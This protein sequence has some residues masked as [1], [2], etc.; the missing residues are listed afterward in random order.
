M[1]HRAKSLSEW[2]QKQEE[3]RATF[4]KEAPKNPTILAFLKDLNASE[5]TEIIKDEKATT[6][7]NSQAEQDVK[8]SVL[9]RM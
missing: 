7:Q 5:S 8:Q 3:I 4:E 1:F 6:I 9:N 2:E